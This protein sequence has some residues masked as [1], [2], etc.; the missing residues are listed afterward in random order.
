MYSQ[1]SRV[2]SQESRVKS[3]ESRVKSQE[4]I[5]SGLWTLDPRLLTN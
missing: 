4:L 1:E 5:Y 2:K 3:Q